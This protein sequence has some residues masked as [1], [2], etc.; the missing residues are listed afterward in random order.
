MRENREREEHFLN[1]R[2]VGREGRRKK[3][4]E[5]KD[6]PLHLLIASYL[7][8]RKKRRGGTL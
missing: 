7:R 8:E 2:R 6:E 3:G 1:T 4:E 5:G